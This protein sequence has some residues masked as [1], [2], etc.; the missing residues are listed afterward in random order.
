MYLCMHV[1]ILVCMYIYACM[2][3]CMLP[4]YRCVRMYVHVCMYVCM[5]VFMY[6]CVR[7]S[8]C[9]YVRTYVRMYVYQGLYIYAKMVMALMYCIYLILPPDFLSCWDDTVLRNLQLPLTMA[10][11]IMYS[12]YMQHIRLHCSNH[13][14]G[15]ECH[16]SVHVYYLFRS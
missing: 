11:S 16:S 4:M 13:Q 8:M 1:C 15:S 6:V 10:L 3:V 9:M 7:M 14:A 12:I 5:Y 2:Y